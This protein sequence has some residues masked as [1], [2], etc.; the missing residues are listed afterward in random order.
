MVF[1]SSVCRRGVFLLVVFV[2]RVATG[3]ESTCRP[4]VPMTADGIRLTPNPFACLD[5][6]REMEEDRS[7]DTPTY[8]DGPAE[9]GLA[10]VSFRQLEAFFNQVPLPRDN[11]LKEKFDMGSNLLL[12]DPIPLRSQ[13]VPAY[14]TRAPAGFVGWNALFSH[15]ISLRDQVMVCDTVYI[16]VDNRDLSN[17][18]NAH[19]IVPHWPPAAA[20][21]ASRVQL[22][23]PFRERTDV[24]SI[25]ICEATGLANVHPTWAGTFVLA[26]M[27][28][29]YP[30]VHFALIDNDCL[31]LTLFEV[32]ELWSLASTERVPIGSHSADREEPTRMES[33]AG[34]QQT[35]NPHKRARTDPDSEPCP[36]QGVILF[37]E[38]H[39]ELNAGLVVICASRHSPIVD[40]SPLD[41]P[42]ATRAENDGLVEKLAADAIVGY[43]R[44]AQRYVS[45]AQDPESLSSEEASI[46]IQT[47]LA[48]TPFAFADT[49]HSVDWAIAWAMI[50]EWTNHQLF[51]PPKSG[52]WPR[53][54]HVNGLE[55]GFHHRQ[56]WLVTWARACFEQGALPSLSVLPRPSASLLLLCS[57][58]ARKDLKPG[59]CEVRSLAGD[60]M[61]QATHIVDGYQRPCVLHGYGGAKSSMPT[62]L[63]ELATKGWTVVAAALLG[64]QGKPPLW[65]QEGC[66]PVIGTTIECRMTPCPVSH[67][68]ESLLLSMWWP[69]RDLDTLE[70]HKSFLKGFEP[71]HS[72][73]HAYTLEG[74]APTATAPDAILALLRD[75]GFP[76]WTLTP[77]PNRKTAVI[78]TLVCFATIVSAEGASTVAALSLHGLLPESFPR[79]A[80]NLAVGTWFRLGGTQKTSMAHMPL[81]Q[82]VNASPKCLVGFTSEGKEVNVELTNTHLC[83][84]TCTDTDVWVAIF[85]GTC[86]PYLNL[87][88]SLSVECTGL[89][90]ADLNS[91]HPWDLLIRTGRHHEDVYGP[92]LARLEFPGAYNQQNVMY[93]GLGLTKATH[94]FV[95]LHYFATDSAQIWDDLE[96]MRNLTFVHAPTRRAKAL[97]ALR[98]SHVAP[99]YR[100]LP[101]PLWTGCM[102]MILRLCLG[103][104]RAQL[105]FYMRRSDAV[106]Q[107]SRPEERASAGEGSTSFHSGDFPLVL[108][109]WLFFSWWWRN[110]WFRDLGLWE[111]LPSHRHLWQSFRH[112]MPDVFEFIISSQTS[113]APG[114]LKT[115]MSLSPLSR[116]SWSATMITT[117]TGT[118]AG[119]AILI[120]TGSGWILHQECTNYGHS[121]ETSLLLDILWHVMRPRFVSSLGCPSG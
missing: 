106:M 75:E 101:H 104:M 2:T 97:R 98:K 92:S 38:P 88:K 113:C 73:S 110:P 93:V 108:L 84:G 7:P 61:F 86:L 60:K 20:W 55:E 85:L 14:E 28:A 103:V 34:M 35:G 82:S 90:G 17:L 87:R 40:L 115:A 26:G 54:A 41:M 68:E 12:G 99:S 100:R 80:W 36:P 39:S 107:R 63:P 24:V 47:G 81:P 78:E 77:P 69:A 105:A 120:V 65:T 43:Q 111:R 109:D 79:H 27:V 13:D 119:M 31:P 58:W 56:P 102:T 33:A 52:E 94:E 95:I 53:F 9:K 25:R 16:L 83:L 72:P 37:T 51:P 11:E 64:T 22:V 49:R 112:V 45:S 46:W 29:L 66:R 71:K 42:V 15:L 30:H 50:G 21:W 118:L 48:L 57:M 62:S 19:G 70:S 5:A 10:E 4:R 8:L 91:P 23:G 67:K 117:W 18:R 44:L 6:E 74:L 32:A 121:A 3:K 59:T 89:G 114:H 1:G 76:L 96:S 116:W